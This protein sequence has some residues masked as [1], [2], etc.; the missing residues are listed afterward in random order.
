MRC[1]TR[2]SPACARA[3]ASRRPSARARR[4][5][6]AALAVVAAL[7]AL[8]CGGRR[9]PL[10]NC[11]PLGPLAPVCGFQNPEDLAVAGDWLLVSQFPAGKRAG[12]LIAFRPSDGTK[13]S[14][15][16]PEGAPDEASAAC[17]PGAPPRAHDFAPHGIDLAGERLLVVNHGE[18]E[19]VEEFTLGQDADG[20]P[21]LAWQ[22]CT[23][24]PDGANANDVAWLADGGFVATN[25]SQGSRVAAVWKMLLEKDTGA[26]LR[27]SAGASDWEIVPSSAARAPNG[28]EVGGDGSL[29]MAEWGARRVRRFAPDGR[30]DGAAQLDFSPD[31][32]SWASDG[33]LLVA[34]QRAAVL[35]AARC[36][37]I[38]E[39][40]C[41]L[42]S[43]VAAIDPR[44]LAVTPLVDD[45]PPTKLGAASVAV[46][47][48]GAL[49]IGTFHGDRLVRR[50]GT[51]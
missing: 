7:L 50:E 41:P 36:L 33:R 43:A 10:T 45:D 34:G 2:P 4:G 29:F 11:A 51:H 31:N 18:R 48:G 40:V 16:P 19:A 13:R 37:W 44:T 6:P 15:F 38:P 28:V 17:A 22:G 1:S 30:P 49:W 12:S 39:G 27:R 25:S 9:S 46:E 35:Q 21:T 47:H 32:L 42:P 5:S 23:K 26:L 8:G 24:L 20:G 14:L 3:S